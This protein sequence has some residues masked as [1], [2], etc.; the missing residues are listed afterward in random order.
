MNRTSTA[1]KTQENESGKNNASTTG[2]RQINSRSRPLFAEHF[3]AAQW[4]ILDCLKVN[5]DSLSNFVVFVEQQ[6]KKKTST[7]AVMPDD[8]L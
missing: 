5:V 1:I 3:L 8:L 7:A 4:E 2:F 6:N